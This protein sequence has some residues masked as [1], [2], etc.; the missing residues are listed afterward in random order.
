MIVECLYVVLQF[1]Q[2]A[3]A[4]KFRYVGARNNSGGSVGTA[5]RLRCERSGVP[6]EARDFS[7]LQNIKT[8]SGAHTGLLS[9][10]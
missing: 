3:P 4:S 1:E 10:G 8:G 6:A 5:T 9:R 7:L 2:P